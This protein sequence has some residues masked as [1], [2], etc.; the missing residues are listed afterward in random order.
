MEIEVVDSQPEVA[1]TP[2]P[3]EVVESLPEDPTAAAAPRE[4]EVAA[5]VAADVASVGSGA[6]GGD[7]L[8]RGLSD[9]TTIPATEEEIQAFR[10]SCQHVVKTI[11]NSWTTFF[12]N[13]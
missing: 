10:V 5:A 6:M 11:S 2:G 1:E 3:A 9:A 7:A 13:N 8:H 12:Q 4:G